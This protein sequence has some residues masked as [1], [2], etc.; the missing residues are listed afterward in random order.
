MPCHTQKPCHTRSSCSLL[1]SDGPSRSRGGGL[2]F[3]D[4]AGGA[5]AAFFLPTFSGRQVA[6]NITTTN[7]SRHAENQV[8]SSQIQMQPIC[9]MTK[10][11]V[12]V[13]R[14]TK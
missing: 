7:V 13:M 1:Q 10:N 6:W 14:R 12:V 3:S 5:T 8:L 11:H 2:L 9:R 4:E